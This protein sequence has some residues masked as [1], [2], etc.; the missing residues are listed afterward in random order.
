VKISFGSKRI[1]LLTGNH[2]IKIGKIRL[3]RF[4][5]RF[6]VLPFSKRLRG[7]FII[8]YGPG[9]KTAL[10]ND[11]FAGLMSN[12]NEY[13]YFQEDKNIHVMPTSKQFLKGHVI[14]QLRGSAVSEKEIEKEFPNYKSSEYREAEL[15]TARQFCRHPDGKIRIADYGNIS[16]I[17]LIKETLNV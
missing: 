14:I 7:R 5:S 16:T 17:H 12:R 13:T 9:W 8:K 1:V 4:V 6:F 2:A 3:V 10:F 11:L 15:N